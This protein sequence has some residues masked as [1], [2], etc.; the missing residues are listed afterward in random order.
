[1]FVVLA[2]EVPSFFA[3]KSPELKLK[4]LFKTENYWFLS[5]Q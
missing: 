1:V 4:V 5:V 3:E 2:S